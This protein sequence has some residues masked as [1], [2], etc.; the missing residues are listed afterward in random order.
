MTLCSEEIHLTR[1]DFGS[2]AFQEIGIFRS[3]GSWI[4]V[5][6]VS[7]I[8]SPWN[9]RFFLPLKIWW[10]GLDSIFFLKFPLKGGPN[11]RLMFRK[12]PTIVD[13]RFV[14]LHL[15]KCHKNTC[16]F[17]RTCSSAAGGFR[18]LNRWDHLL[19]WWRFLSDT[20]ATR[21]KRSQDGDMDVNDNQCDMLFW[22]ILGPL[23]LMIWSHVVVRLAPAFGYC[24]FA[25]RKPR[26]KRWFRQELDSKGFSL[27]MDWV[28][29]LYN[30]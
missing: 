30:I 26:G 29:I 17:F 13:W 12:M 23:S 14:Q 25:W 27:M 21:R 18:S 7:W 3:P 11:L 2:P 16:F 20:P 15:E 8:F 10:L 19:L 28:I 9:Q 1:L 4:L 22:N 6:V 5:Q 24:T